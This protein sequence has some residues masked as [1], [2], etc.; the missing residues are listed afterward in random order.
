[1]VKSYIDKAK[2]EREAQ[3]T[4]SWMT[5][6]FHRVKKMPELDKLLNGEKKAQTAK[7]MLDKIKA[8]NAKFGGTVE[9][10]G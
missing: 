4:Q 3:L 8:L 9:K 10:G 2:R 1:M 6:Y 7:E 5:A